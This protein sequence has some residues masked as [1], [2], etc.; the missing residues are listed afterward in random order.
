MEP[1]IAFH[2]EIYSLTII[3]FCSMSRKFC[4]FSAAF[5]LCFQT[6]SQIDDKGSGRAVSFDGVDDYINLGNIY[7]DLNLPLTI[8]AWIYI[9]HSATLPGP[10]FVSQDN[11]PDNYNG[12]WLLVSTSQIIFE[13][14]DGLGSNN[15]AF[16]RGKIASVSNM[17]NRWIH[18][19]G[20]MKSASDIQIYV[21]GI[22]IGGSPSG[23]SS[24][25]MSSNFPSDV[26]KIGYHISNAVVYR[27]R[28]LLDEIRLY[29]R[30][31][32]EIEVREGMCK[33]L[34]GTESGLIGYWNFD[35]VSG[36]SILDKSPEGY[37]G[38][39]VNGPS[40][41][42][43]G[44]PLGDES[45]NLYTGAW[46][47]TTV[48]MDEGIHTVKVSNIQGNPQ[49]LH[50]YTVRNVPSQ[51][52]GLN[53]TVMPPYFGVFTAALDINNTFD[54]SLDDN[55]CGMFTRKDNSEAAWTSSAALVDVADR[56]EF[57][58][59]SE[60]AELGIDLGPDEFICPFVPVTLSPL[61]NPAGYKFLWQNGSTQPTFHATE[62]G[63]YWVTVSNACQ[64]DQ[65]TITFTKKETPLSINLGLDEFICPLE[66]RLLSP[67]DNPT[68]YEFTWQDGSKQ[69]SLQISHYG[70]YWVTVQ[71][72]CS[73]ASDTITVLKPE[74]TRFFI[75]NVITPN[76][77]AKNDFFII[78]QQ[79]VGSS[80]SV[81]N[82]WGRRVY[83]SDNYQNDWDGKDL[84]G[85]IYYYFI[86]NSCAENQKG[87]LSILR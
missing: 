83:E 30:A 56:I 60:V 44:A 7:D 74:F 51:T 15:P 10:I 78:D 38:L 70:K 55:V 18:I 86:T 11:D 35:E 57:I 53:A 68:G 28:G 41:V 71:N 14:G 6:F 52:Q 23:N 13:F 12:F 59:G 69:S 17:A 66:P 87:Y 77:D 80:V 61:A 24:S 46:T 25:P 84:P 5:L 62:Y 58:E 16:R 8:S 22:N 85:G 54:V 34:N 4:F 82:R 50:I 29:N 21:N 2:K 1:F 39:F 45:I 27:Y 20:V 9:D 48:S 33:K 32:T 63:V 3:Y 31:L 76:D 40:R 47:G 42:Y 26:A 79:L 19:C 67:L 43:S 49:G 72:G 36:N 64:I 73:M 75:P 65:D 81:Y 37:N